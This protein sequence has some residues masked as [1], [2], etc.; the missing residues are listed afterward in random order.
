MKFYFSIMIADLTLTN[1]K[2]IK[3]MKT[4][5]FSSKFNYLKKFHDKLINLNKIKSAKKMWN[6]KISVK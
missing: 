6:L 2:M 4:I 3:T 1:T 5:F